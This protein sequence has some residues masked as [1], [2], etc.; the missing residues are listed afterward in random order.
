VNDDSQE[1]L[2]RQV[3]AVLTNF[4]NAVER[5]ADALMQRIH[6]QADTIN[7]LV[8]RVLQLEQRD[9]RFFAPHPVG[10]VTWIAHSENGT[11]TAYTRRTFPT[12]Q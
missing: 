9:A 2:D 1:K 5:E 11:S 4:R 7:G 10:T 3:E 8:E 6:E 12:P